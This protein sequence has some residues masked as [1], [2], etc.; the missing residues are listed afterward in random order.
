MHVE[1]RVFYSWLEVQ[2]E[3]ATNENARLHTW[4]YSITQPLRWTVLVYVER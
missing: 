3:L 1:R 4:P 2:N